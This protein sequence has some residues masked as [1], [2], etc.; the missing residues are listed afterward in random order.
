[1][2]GE[3]KKIQGIGDNTEAR[4]CL[5]KHES[6]LSLG[7]MLVF[8]GFGLARAV[9]VFLVKASQKISPFHIVF[10]Q[11]PTKQIKTTQYKQK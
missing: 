10:G 9:L 4:P 2:N 11:K 1:M 7:Q 6:C 8:G 5:P 3:E